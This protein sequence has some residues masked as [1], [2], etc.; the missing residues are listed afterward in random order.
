MTA[1]VTNDPR[2]PI[3]KFDLAAPVTPERL[4]QALED[5]SRLPALLRDAVRGLSSEQLEV[6]YRD[7]G[8]TA[9]QIAHHIPDSHL[10]G[11]TRTKLALTEDAPTIKPYDQTKWAELADVRLAP[12]DAS[13]ALLEGLQARWAALG[14]SL[15]AAE[16]ERVYVNPES[17][18][19]VPLGAHLCLYGWHGRHHVGQI[20][21][22]R[23]R[24]GWK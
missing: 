1:P 24:M 13:F 15:G 6:P 2:Y 17:G 4:A 3:G 8:W 18:K 12:I 10:N 20:L 9:R 5:M 23:E 11:Y 16:L 7:G 19:R 21:S 14:R 22:L